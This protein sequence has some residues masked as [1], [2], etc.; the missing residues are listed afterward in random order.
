[1]KLLQIMRPRHWAKNVFVFAALIFGQKITD[2]L[3]VVG[4]IGGFFCFCL[5]ASAIYIINDIIDRRT[6]SLHPEKC[7]RPIA[8]GSVS[9]SSAVLVSALCAAAAI[10]GGFVLARNFATVIMAYIVL[11]IFYSLLFKRMMILDCVVISIGFCLRAI[12]GAIAVGV[13]ISPWL[14][15]C[16]FALCLFLAFSKRRG[17]IIL[18]G[19]NSESFRETLAGYTPELLAHMLDVT[20]G[21]AV[22]CFLLYAMDDRTLRIF[23]TNNLVYTTPLVLYCI[24]RFSLLIQQGSFSDPLQ[25]M[26]K[27][28]PFQIGLVLWVL[29]CIGIIYADKLG[30]G[31]T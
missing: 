17:E 13:S 23:G 1:M 30:F 21:L 8:A 28:L 26:Y 9:I 16:T 18:L 5:A 27:D 10:I 20:S 2:P 15:I 12:A 4:A 3:A 19:E 6:D 14:I 25:L 22:V 24:F 31:G 29:S 11:M 7:K